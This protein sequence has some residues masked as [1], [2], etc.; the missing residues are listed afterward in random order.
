MLT[1]SVV[2][3]AGEW[4]ITVNAVAPGPVQTG[5]LTLEQE[6]QEAARVPLGRIGRPED[7]ANVILFL[8]SDLAEWVTGQVLKVDGGTG[9]A[10]K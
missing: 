10:L 6:K 2:K 9:H 4:G 1:R 3:A 7:L 8:A 5:Y